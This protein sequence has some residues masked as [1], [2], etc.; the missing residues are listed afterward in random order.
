[1]LFLITVAALTPEPDNKKTEVY[2]KQ[3][4]SIV[5]E[6]MLVNRWLFLPDGDNVSSSELGGECHVRIPRGT[7]AFSRPLR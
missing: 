7:P 3:R 1:M 2:F 4:I 6:P 5:F